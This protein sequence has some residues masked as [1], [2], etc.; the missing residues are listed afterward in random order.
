MLQNLFMLKSLPYKSIFLLLGAVSLPLI[1]RVVLTALGASLTPQAYVLPFTVGGTLG[2]LIGFLLVKYIKTLEALKGT[3]S[4]LQQEIKEK[5]LSEAKYAT[6]FERN[7]TVTLLINPSTGSIVDANTTAC[8]FY[9][10]PIEEIRRM[11]IS[12]INVLSQEE[13]SNEMDRAIQEGRQQY[14][15]KHRLQSGDVRD[16]E[17][18]S[19][20]IVINGSTLLLS[21]VNDITQLKLLRGIIPICLHCKQ[22][23]D[24]QG[25]WSQLELYI[26]THSEADFSHGLCPDCAHKLY[27]DIFN[28]RQ[29]L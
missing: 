20:P 25:F 5:T 18:Y 15:F 6:L 17:V 19:G 28:E 29:Q 26:K 24:D 23:R 9:G 10:Y 21:I 13:I 1:A 4:A 7:H 2:Y 11:F 12:D 14:Y 3:N 8:A 27:P 16:V 22:I